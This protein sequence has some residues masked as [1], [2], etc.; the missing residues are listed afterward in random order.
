MDQDNDTPPGLLSASPGNEALDE[1]QSLLPSSPVKTQQ[2]R[3]GFIFKVLATMFSFCVLGLYTSTTGVI[4]PHLEKHYGLSDGQVSFIFLASPVGYIFAAQLNDV[5]HSRLGQRGIALIG[6]LSH[7]IFTAGAS[8]H[9]SFPWFLFFMTIGTFG[10]GV[11]DGSWCA[12]AGALERASTISGFLHGSYS[13]GAAA[14]P[15]LADTLISDTRPWFTWYYVLFGAAL[16]ELMI[17]LLAFRTD[18]AVSYH[19]QKRR[20]ENSLQSSNTGFV[21]LKY[22]AVWLCSAYLLTYAGTETSISGW[23]VIFMERERNASTFIASLC[24]SVFW[25]GMAVGR[26]ALGAP[27]DRLGV[28][29]AVL[30]YTLLALLFTILFGVIPNEVVSVT[31]LSMLGFFCG[32]LF[33][34]SIVLLTAAL[35]SELHVSGVSFVASMGQVGGTFLPFGLGWIIDAVGMGAFQVIFITQLV[36]SLLVWILYA[37]L[38]SGSRRVLTTG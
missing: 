2:S 24:S 13:V 6:P 25:T 31:M 33:P 4:L 15:L 37:R 21:V 3:G 30:L 22:S 34:S 9:P 7:L 20:D 18:N 17:L 27:T 5:I 8:A 16:L 29:L 23:I 1:T 10:I 38:V 26:L 28:K 36:I 35:P 32:P 14:G 19:D 12:W 11:L